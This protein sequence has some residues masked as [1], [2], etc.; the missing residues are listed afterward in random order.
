MQW[1]TVD[2]LFVSAE[3]SGPPTLDNG[4]INGTNTY[5]DAGFRYNVSFIE[6]TSYRIRLVN[7]AV[8]THFKFMI[9]N[10]TLTVIAADLVPIVPYTTTYLDI[11]M[12]QR[13]DII[14]TADQAAVA[15]SFWLRAIPQSACS[16]QLPLTH[17]PIHHQFN[18]PADNDNADDI[19]GIV[20][21]TTSL[22]TP[23]TSAYSYTDTCADETPNLTPY[24]SKSVP[25]PSNPTLE[26]ATVGFNSASVFRWYLNS[27]TMLTDWATPTLSQILANTT[28]FATS[29]AVIE[30]PDAD[31]WV[32]ILI[33][34]ALAVPHPIHLHGHDFAVLAQGSGTYDADSTTLSLENPPRRDT[35]MLPAEGYLLV[36]F[37]TDNPGAWLIHCHIGW[38]TSEGFAL[39]FV[40]REGE[41]AGITDGT[42]LSEGCEAWSAWQDSAGIEQEDSGV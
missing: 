3:T 20:Y 21:Y 32:Y 17:T 10:H 27:T 42:R 11:G 33:E 40:E 12:G 8:D 4:L 19:R 30:L 13:Y 39:Q 41:I 35:A 5:G 14:V 34:T 2:E 24:L 7:G 26:T 25:A 31:E 23:S 22:T 28:S 6:A 15:D 36:A 29:S 16:G 37:E 9:D 18:L 1:Q 38:H